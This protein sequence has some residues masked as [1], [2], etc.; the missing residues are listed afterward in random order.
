MFIFAGFSCRDPGGRTASY[1]AQSLR[2]NQ[3]KLLSTVQVSSQVISDSHHHHHLRQHIH[4]HHHLRKHIHHHHYQ[5]HHH[6]HHQHH[7]KVSTFG[8]LWKTEG[9]AECTKLSWGKFRNFSLK[10]W[11]KNFSKIPKLLVD[12]I[13]CLRTS[14]WRTWRRFVR[15]FPVPGCALSSRFES[16]KLK[17][18]NWKWK[19]VSALLQVW[20]LKDDD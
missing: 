12:G 13:R 20:T 11:K 17:V 6:H 4:H 16:S 5:H 9:G 19:A 8:R 18:E 7:P 10:I 15:S 3:H 1:A 2:S 14:S